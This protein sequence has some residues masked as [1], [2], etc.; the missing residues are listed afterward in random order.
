MLSTS[1]FR[2]AA[3]RSGPQHQSPSARM[4]FDAA[5]D[6]I[7]RCG[8][9]LSGVQTGPVK[10]VWLDRIISAFWI[11]L[12]ISSF[13]MIPVETYRRLFTA[14]EAPSL[15][16]I[17]Q[18][19]HLIVYT[20]TPLHTVFRLKLN[21]DKL[22]PL[23]RE[24]GHRFS[25][26]AVPCLC[27]VCT[28]AWY[29]HNIYRKSWTWIHVTLWRSVFK[30]SSVTFFLIYS[31]SISSVTEDQKDIPD[32]LQKS[33]ASFDELSMK[34][35]KNRARIASTNSLFSEILCIHYVQC[36]LLTFTLLGKAAGY[37]AYSAHWTF[38]LASL[39]STSIQL[40]VLAQKCSSFY[41]I[42]A[43]TDQNLL[44]QIRGSNFSKSCHSELSAVLRFHDV[45]D[46]FKLGCFSH[47]VGN[48]LSFLATGLTCAAVALQFDFKVV[49]ALASTA[50]SEAAVL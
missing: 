49:R 37:N 15:C 10:K 11:T 23:L 16:E 31:D 22:K 3:T 42:C 19:A 46:V 20:A 47:S 21:E 17:I 14:K 13:Y 29:F 24:Q 1:E 26:V 39:V 32:S 43:D 28:L 7:F 50:S 44:M 18:A 41:Q 9:M 25:D 8:C 48:L 5:W 2:G 34:K 30:L 27:T 4:K 40:F 12:L 45:W 6:V 33:V 35:W 38:L 36:L